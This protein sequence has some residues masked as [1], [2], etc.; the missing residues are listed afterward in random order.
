[1]VPETAFSPRYLAALAGGAAAALLFFVG[2]LAGLERM[3][4]LPPP[5]LTNSLCLDEKL[6]NLRDR[7][8]H[9]TPSLIAIGSSVAWR[10]FDGSAV[11]RRAPEALP[12]NGGFCG[13]NLRQ[14][15]FAADWLLERYPSAREVVAIVAP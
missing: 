9:E 7:H 12:L 3:G 2:G 8:A 10:H 14:S 4:R 6:A 13:L 15:V 5:A 11:V 1:M